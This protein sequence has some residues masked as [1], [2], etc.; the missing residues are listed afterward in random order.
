MAY[1]PNCGSQVKDS[2]HYCG[3]C[4]K[5]LSESS[6]LEDES[7]LEV[8]RDGFLSRRSIKYVNEL[9]NGERKLDYESVAFKQLS[10]DVNAG[11]A[12]F[13]RLSMVEDLNLLLLWMSGVNTESLTKSVEDMNTS[14]YQDRLGALGLIRTLRMYDD[15]LQ[16]EFEATFEDRL[17]DLI[18]FGNGEVSKDEIPE[19]L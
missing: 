12:D 3:T 16:T 1:C 9:L 5:G 17:Q 10:R 14:Q 18:E 13:A 15:A 6:K 4:G 7:P 2:H 11:F 8:N 19:W